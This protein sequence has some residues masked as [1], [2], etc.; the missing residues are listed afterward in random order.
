MTDQ[1]IL[2][3]ARRCNANGWVLT[4]SKDNVSRILALLEVAVLSQAPKGEK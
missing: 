1:Q 3:W 4:Y 2:D